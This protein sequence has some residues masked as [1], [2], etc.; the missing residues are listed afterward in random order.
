MIPT[1]G[2]L[3]NTPID[4]DQQPST[5]YRLDL[6]N[7]RVIGVVDGL[8]AVKQAVYKILQS[9]RYEH[10]IYSF[11]Y[12]HELTRLLGRSPQYVQSEVTRLITEGLTQDDRIQTVEG[13]RIST[14]EDNMLVVFN[15]VSS[16]GSFEVTQEVS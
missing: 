2:E 12:G 14:A 5:T 16:F 11:D 7:G 15:V 6:E 9:P 13:V 10:D 4:F 1:G 8:E 3:A